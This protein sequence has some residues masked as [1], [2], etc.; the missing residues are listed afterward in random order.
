MPSLYLDIHTLRCQFGSS[1]WHHVLSQL[2]YGNFLS[3]EI[4]FGGPNELVGPL[5]QAAEALQQSITVFRLGTYEEAVADCRPGFDS[6][7][8]SDRGPFCLRPLDGAADGKRDVLGLWPGE[9]G[10]GEGA[11]LTLRPSLGLLAALIPHRMG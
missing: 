10:Y 7:E 2:E 11:K 6:L 1:D 5:Q 9:H 8:D 3:I 4:P